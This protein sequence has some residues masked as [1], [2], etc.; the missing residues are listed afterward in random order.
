MRWTK[1]TN[2]V[3][4]PT[5][6]A[7]LD[8]SAYASDSM[9]ANEPAPIYSLYAVSNHMGEFNGFFDSGLIRILIFWEF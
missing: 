5:G 1:M 4:F 9:D 3:E 6:V 8:L 7:E 2:V